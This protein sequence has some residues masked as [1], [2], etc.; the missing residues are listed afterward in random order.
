MIAKLAYRLEDVVL[1][2]RDKTSA[3]HEHILQQGSLIT[4]IMT[5]PEE[6]IKFIAWSAFQ[7]Y[8]VIE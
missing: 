2:G 1:R 4:L 6:N 3:F 7:S 8:H 5:L